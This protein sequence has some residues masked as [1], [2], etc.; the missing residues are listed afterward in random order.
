[1]VFCIQSFL[2]PEASSW[3]AQKYNPQSLQEGWNTWS[4]TTN[5][6]QWRENIRIL[7]WVR[8]W[9]SLYGILKM[10]LLTQTVQLTKYQMVTIRTCCNPQTA[11]GLCPSA[12]G[13][14]IGLGHLVLFLSCGTFPGRYLGCWSESYI[15]AFWVQALPLLNFC[16]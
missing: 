3:M 6:V 5:M 9:L 4:K 16:R 1:M 11:T 13:N 10:F 12:K 15:D 8:R 7:W 14:I 2:N